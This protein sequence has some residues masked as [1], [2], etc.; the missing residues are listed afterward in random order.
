MS[1]RGGSRGTLDRSTSAEVSLAAPVT[2]QLA[3]GHNFCRTKPAALKETDR[4]FTSREPKVRLRP[5][6]KTG[7]LVV[8][9]RCSYVIEDYKSFIINKAEPEGFEPSVRF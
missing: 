6:L 9:E 3:V 4:A 7:E 5:R 2:L 1:L 8:Q